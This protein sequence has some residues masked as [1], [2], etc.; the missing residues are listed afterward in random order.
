MKPKEKISQEDFPK[1]LQQQFD[2][3]ERRLWLV[4]TIMA[5]CL[6]TAGL[7]G[8]YLILFFSDRLWDSP[9][10]LRLGLLASGIVITLSA[11]IWWSYRWIFKKRDT[12]AIACLVQRR[13]RRL[14]DRLLGI[15]ELANEQ[16]RPAIFSPA[17]YRAAIEQVAD[18]ALKLDFKQTVSPRP[19]RRRATIATSLIL[20]AIAGWIIIPEAGLNTLRRWSQPGA[21]ISRHTL[22]QLDGFPN[23][24]IVAKGEPF[25]ISG[26]IEYRSFWKPK[27]ASAQFQ[28]N[29]PK[30]AMI[31]DGKVQ[32]TVP[33]QIEDGNLTVKAGD[34]KQT[35]KIRP[36]QRP[37]MRELVAEV[38]LPNYLNYP[39]Q[40]E[41][42]QAGFLP[43]L[44][45]SKITFRGRVS[46]KLKHAQ[47]AIDDV[48]SQMS[49][50]SDSFS[51]PLHKV[52]DP[53]HFSFT[54]CDEHN[55]TE[56]AAW[57]LN[58]EPTEDNPP[59]P[60]LE[61]QSR[62]MAILET[63]VLELNATV[64]DDYGIKE[65]GI[66][67]RVLGQTEEA[68]PKIISSLT[69]ETE[70]PQEKDM[71]T[72]F[73]FSP[74]VLGIG[75]DTTIEL[76][77]W[78]TDHLPGRT[79]IRTSPIQLHI[80]GIED[81]AEMVRQKLEEVL[82]NLEEVS[83][84]EENI[85]EDTRE[86]A[87]SDNE[88]LDKSKT[89]EKIENTADEQRDN[90]EDLKNLVKEGANA[91]MEAMQNPAF[92][93]QTLQDW[94]ENLKSMNDLADQQM[95]A[96]E[97]KLSQAAQEGQVEEKK[98]SLKEAL[99]EEEEALD[100]L[101][102]LQDKVNKD[103]DNLQALTLA[104][105]LR[106][107]SKEE[108][109]LR[110]KIK[111]IIQ[112]T[113]GLTPKDL[114]PRYSRANKRFTKSQNRTQEKA[115]ELQGEISRFYER[116]AKGQYGEVSREME[117]EKTG[118]S[119]SEIESQIDSNIS[120]LAIRNL[121]D[122]AD[123]FEGWAK[124]LEP[125]KQESDGD[126]QGAGQGGGE[127]KEDNLMKLLF[128]MLRLRES[129]LKHRQQTTLIE[130]QKN[131]IDIYNKGVKR[132]SEMHADSMLE[133]N[134]LQFENSEPAMLTPLQ[135]AF[136]SMEV[137][138]NLLDKPQTDTIT[139][140]SQSETIRNISDVINLIN[141]EIKRDQNQ[142]G[143][144]KTQQQMDF[145]MAM[146]AMKQQMGQGMQQ[147]QTAG[148][149]QAGGTTSQAANGLN[150]NSVGR[151]DLDRTI[152]KG[153]GGAG[154]LPEEFREALEGYFKAVEAIEEGKQP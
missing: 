116:T 61:S 63:E 6:S 128:S 57:Q 48:D 78:A 19:A 22:V 104:Q 41:T 88:T 138:D 83:R 23:Q 86:L 71:E 101:A 28:N 4:E 74:A 68:A 53:S 120:M 142:E 105:R 137:T 8:S 5:V 106:K 80:L 129:E 96:A 103:L 100:E 17:L 93:E 130:Q 50:H 140:A 45:G 115:V 150:G 76:K 51:S 21:N 108:L 24:Q 32:F 99:E 26:T 27:I 37:A 42:V 43:V 16:K 119:L 131:D 87:K 146:M 38:K 3:V 65:A 152:S 125:P 33:G 154:K 9:N 153:S 52:T 109:A 39:T 91:L 67:W 121:G 147:G 134:R 145:M 144:S 143:Q 46:R 62:S 18:E 126:S 55:L 77:V 69:V 112:E 111:D 132:L 127:K 58:V 64:N 133:L 151:D 70:G 102:D 139:T 79:P 95:K 92:D 30:A 59:R 60:D 75:R 124:K 11:I 98:E 81:H 123:K 89:N 73:H 90:A 2:L 49:V 113:I 118:E 72:R 136:D 107:L 47:I 117:T 84:T 10:W 54:W 122:W 13:Y 148:G 35:I 40:N 141:E 94:A 15:V 12:R 29:Q 20:L 82:E 1:D 44:R 56:A 110:K 114:P 149:S 14:G 97:S 36:L 31:N 7:F 25:D 66:E 135:D 85:A 34:S